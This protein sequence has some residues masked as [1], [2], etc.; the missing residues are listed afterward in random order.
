P[1]TRMFTDATPP[2]STN[3]ITQGMN[4]FGRITG[5]GFDIVNG[6]YG[7][8][9]QQGTITKSKRELLPF[10]DRLKIGVAG[11]ATRGINDSGVVVGFTS[12]PDATNSGFVG[13]DASGYLRLVPPGGEVTG[14]STVCEGIN[15]FAQVVCFVQDPSMTTL[16]AFIGSPSKGEGNADSSSHAAPT[17]NTASSGAAEW[18]NKSRGELVI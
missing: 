3:T 8:V 5:H 16:G 13:S 6:R 18:I 15:N 12:N 14:N 11:A 10:L 17:R 2:G 1:D 4:A 7:F 9:W